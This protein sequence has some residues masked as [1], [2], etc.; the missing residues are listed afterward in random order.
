MDPKSISKEQHSEFY[1]FI[2]NSL[3]K[4]RFVMHY[5]SDAPLTIRALFYFPSTKPRKFLLILVIYWNDNKDNS[6]LS[7]SSGLWNESRVWCYSVYE[8]SINKE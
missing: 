6:I 5:S 1:Q 2:S 8:E 3:D 4:P 7:F